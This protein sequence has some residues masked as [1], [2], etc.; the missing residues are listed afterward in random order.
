MKPLTQSIVLVTGASGGIGQACVRAFTDAGAKV[1]ATDVKG[2][3]CTPVDIRNERAVEQL[4]A[5]IE[6]LDVLVNNAAIFRPMKPAH[7]TT[8]AEFDQLIAVNL[9]GLFFCCKHAYRLL[10]RSKGC[11]V[12]VSSMAGVHGEK[13]HAV[14]CA[15]KG[16]INALT[17]A[18]AIDY[19][20]DGIRCNAICPSSVLTPN[21]DALVNEARD[22]A[23]IVEMRRRITQLGYTAKPEEIASVAVFLASP[24]ASFMTG[25]IVPVS[26]G[27]ECGYGIKP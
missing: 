1:I 10:Q 5:G 26:G 4:F 12:N 18:M 23:A 15:T 22:P 8:A 16:A 27:S 20:A 13:G 7:E 14:Y 6:S 21:T 3:G 24:A 19:G 17:Q 9:R 11:I 2:D 25:A